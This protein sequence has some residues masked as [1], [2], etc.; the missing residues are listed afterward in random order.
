MGIIGQRILRMERVDS[1]NAEAA[2]GVAAGELGHGDVVTA[3][4]QTAGRGRRGGRWATAPGLDMACSVVLCP[5]D[6]SAMEQFRLAK[7]VAVAVR[8]VVAGHMERTGHD[9]G[10][11]RIK[12]PNDILVGRDKVAGILLEN[13][14]RGS[15]VAMSVVGVGLNVNSTGFEEAWQATSLLVATG[16]GAPLAEVLQV[17]LE[18]MEQAWQR[19]A[20]EPEALAREYTEQLWARGRFTDFELDGRPWR[21]RALEVD[22]QGRLVV[23]SPGSSVMAYGLER[24]RYGPRN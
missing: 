5:E 8:S 12:W 21:G 23:E 13:E 6:L 9:P 17:L 15:R 14:L 19:M 16:T 24:L 7:A 18:A 10:N 2:R 11:V 3:L 1:T 20:K 4:E 22:A